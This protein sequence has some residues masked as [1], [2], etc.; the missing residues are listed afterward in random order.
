[1]AR[2]FEVD[3]RLSDART[4]AEASLHVK[5][6]VDAYLVLARLDL[7][8]NQTESAAQATDRALQLEP[9]NPTALALK[10]SV[11]AKLAQKAQPLLN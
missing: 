1:L 5:P 3:D 6:T 4:E 8:D 11:A 9:N 7:R 2:A 10:R